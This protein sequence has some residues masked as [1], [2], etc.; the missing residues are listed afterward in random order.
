MAFKARA[1]AVTFLV[2]L[3]LP[4]L[5]TRAVNAAETSDKLSKPIDW[6]KCETYLTAPNGDVMRDLLALYFDSSV[7]RLKAD[8]KKTFMDYVRRAFNRAPDYP[9]LV[10][11]ATVEDASPEWLSHYYKVLRDREMYENKIVNITSYEAWKATRSSQI[12]IYF[13]NIY[14]SHVKTNVAFLSFAKNVL[15]GRVMPWV[16]PHGIPLP[17]S[18]AP[19]V[20]YSEDPSVLRAL[21]STTDFV[22]P[23]QS[24]PSNPLKDS[25][26]VITKGKAKVFVW[27][28]A[29]Q[30]DSEVAALLREGLDQANSLKSDENVILNVGLQL[31]QSRLFRRTRGLR[32]WPGNR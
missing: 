8:D 15:D 32:P 2:F 10:A 20:Y 21:L 5:S 11:P 28:L 19:N 16:P 13:A 23:G 18:Y 1:S 17:Q 27:V 12:Q 26:V 31:R 7:R 9:A 30:T 14:E 24:E 4:L 3:I 29:A 22:F 6:S 25:R